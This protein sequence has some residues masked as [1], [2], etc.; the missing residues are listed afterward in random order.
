MDQELKVHQL[1]MTIAKFCLRDVSFAVRPGEYYVLLGPTGSGK[2]MLMETICGLRASTSGFITLGGRD[3]TALDPSRRGIGYVPQDYALL[4]FRT[5]RGNIAFGLESRRL[6]RKEVT[7]RVDEMLDLLSIRHVSDHYPNQLSGGERQRTAL[8]RALA[9]RPALL[10][11]DEPFSAIDEEMREELG[12]QIRAL[13]QRLRTTT[14]HICH[15][16]EEAERLGDRVSIMHDGQL[17]Q[18]G[19]PSDVIRR[20]LDV[21]VARFL[22]VPN[23]VRGQVRTTGGSRMFHVGACQ[24]CPSNIEDGPATALF[25]ADRLHLSREQ[26]E[27]P[28]S[29]RVVFA[30]RVRRIEESPFR[31]GIHLEEQHLGDL[32][33]PG[34]FPAEEWNPGLPLFVTLDVQDIHLLPGDGLESTLRRGGRGARGHE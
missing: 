5:V 8:G 13:Q 25:P 30:V 10:I 2:T 29:G 26:P 21:F 18:S 7:L 31:P 6:S 24:V 20:P 11:L 17:V 15:S 9:V 23:R 4:P 3:I 12:T 28:G 16:L 34:I 33:I 22:R 19:R 14:L 27:A 32:F 1:N